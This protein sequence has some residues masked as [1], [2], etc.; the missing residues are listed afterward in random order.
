MQCLTLI[1]ENPPDPGEYRVFNQFQ[2]VFDITELAMKV[3]AAAAEM[4][5]DVEVRNI[6]NPRLELEDH[7]YAPDHQHLFDLGYTALRRGGGA[8]D[9]AGAPG[10]VHGPHRGEAGRAAFPTSAGTADERRRA[11]STRWS[12]QRRQRPHGS[13]VLRPETE[14]VDTEEPAL[15]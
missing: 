4:G 5:L 1:L 10:A 11:S 8:G 15:G 12:R 9:D 14:D 7:F 3:Q 2:E 13:R 6:E